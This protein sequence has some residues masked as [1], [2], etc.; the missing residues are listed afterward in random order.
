MNVFGV[1]GFTTPW[2]LLSLLALPILWVLLRAV[3]PAPRRRRFAGVALLLRIADDD[4]QADK[5]PWWLLLLR[6]LVLLDKDKTLVL[7]SSN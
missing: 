5:T 2:L 1:L 7:P 3:P 4:V 6:A